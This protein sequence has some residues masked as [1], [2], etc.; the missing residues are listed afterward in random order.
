MYYGGGAVSC[1]SAEQ[2]DVEGLA[3]VA[4]A[5]GVGHELLLRRPD[6]AEEHAHLVVAQAVGD[7]VVGGV[8][9]GAREAEVV[10]VFGGDRGLVDADVA[11]Q[12]EAVAKVATSR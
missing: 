4:L 11:L 2:A 7:V 1:P 8:V 6:V 10:A 9:E 12:I 5:L 3:L